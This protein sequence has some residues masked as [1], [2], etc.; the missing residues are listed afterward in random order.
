MFYVPSNLDLGEFLLGGSIIDAKVE[1]LR[2][3]EI[4]PKHKILCMSDIELEPFSNRFG[5]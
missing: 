3:T 4:Y 1:L 2:G 5:F